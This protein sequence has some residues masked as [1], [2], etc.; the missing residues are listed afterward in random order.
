MH[1]WAV[2]I[3]FSELLSEVVRREE[4]AWWNMPLIP[5]FRRQSKEDLSEFKGNQGYMEKLCLKLMMMMMKKMMITMII[6]GHEFGR[7]IGGRY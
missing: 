7:K 1:I 5:E 2:L 4:Q 3:R 6:I